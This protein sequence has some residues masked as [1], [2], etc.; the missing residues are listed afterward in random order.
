M[1]ISAGNIDVPRQN[2]ESEFSE[3]VKKEPAEYA[4]DHP[5][6]GV[7]R[8]GDQEFG[9][10]LDSAPSEKP[11]DASDTKKKEKKPAVTQTERY[12]RLFFDVNHN[13][14]L[15]DDPV[16]KAEVPQGI[17]FPP[18]YASFAFPRVDITLDINGKS[19]PY[20]FTFSVYCNSYS[21][22]NTQFQYASA[23]LSAAAYR[24]GTIT[25]DG[26]QRQV[27]V[28]DFNSNG[29]FDDRM[30]VDPNV[31][32]SDGTVYPS[33]GD[34][35][36]VDFSSER[37]S[38]YGYDPTANDAQQYLSPWLM[39]EGEYYDLEITPGGDELTLRPSAVETGYVTNPNKG[40]RAVVY[41]DEGFLKIMGDDS[42]KCP[43]PVGEWRLASYTI[44]RTGWAEEEEPEQD[45]PS[46]LESLSQLLTRPP[47]TTSTRQ[48]TMVS[49][50]A[51]TDYAAVKVKA[52]ETTAL[53][54]GPP[55]KPLVSASMRGSNQASLGM[56]LVG[57]GGEVC[58]NLVVDGRRPPDPRFTITT[59]D[60]KE[61]EQG[62]FEYG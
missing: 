55:Y 23:T 16:V 3:V 13:G 19:V 42:G 5:F 47:P 15:T 52:G 1:Q 37:G 59:P 39:V 50:R 30:K 28:I 33:T 61:I 18:Q 17:R 36:Y 11:S 45:S 60:G 27:V 58:S 44:D 43:L 49:A 31:R 12:T 53:P 7:A 9:F 54:F 62:K 51:K 25:L 56:S 14:D 8:F 6:R 26:K 32:L 4:S 38:S 2:N 34:M 46:L 57:A 41:N 48:T 40:Y 21:S 29:R 24:S 35:V 22:G 10:V 20:A